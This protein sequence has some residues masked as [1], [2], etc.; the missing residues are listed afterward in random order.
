MFKGNILLMD[1]TKEFTKEIYYSQ[2]KPRKF[3]REKYSYSSQTI[4]RNIQGNILM[5]KT[6]EFIYKGN[7]SYVLARLA[8]ITNKTKEFLRGKYSP[9]TWT[10]QSI[11]KGKYYSWTKQW[12]FR[13][14]NI[15]YR[16][17]KEF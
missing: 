4:P 13:K 9:C 8:H 6:M 17:T 1:K 12:N 10:K 5:D 7:I 15:I 16:Q 14:K 3:L 2:A 11:F